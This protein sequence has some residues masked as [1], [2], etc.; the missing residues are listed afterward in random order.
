MA[1]WIFQSLVT[2][3][4]LAATV[5]I[6]CRFGRIGP[7][8]RHALWVVVLVKFVTPP[9]VVWPWAAPDPFGL[10]HGPEVT[11]AIVFEVAKMPHGV[12]GVTS[13]AE[14]AEIAATRA[15]ESPES[16]EP[17]SQ[18][19][20]QTSTVLV[21]LWIAGSVCLLAIEGVRLLRQA[22]RVAMALP[23]A[24]AIEQRV[25]LLA[26][27]LAVSPVPVLTMPGAMSPVVWCLGRP[28][29]LWPAELGDQGDACID[30]LIVHELAHIARRDHI[31]G[32]LELVAGVM[33][34]WNP[35][36]WSVRRA[37]REQAELACDAW[38]ISALPNGRRA[39]AESLLALSSLGAAPAASIAAI[40]GVRASSRRVLERRLVMIMKGRAPLRLP[41]A[42][43]IA[44]VVVTMASLPAWASGQIAGAPQ[45]P[46]PATSAQQQGVPVVV[47][48]SPQAKPPAQPAQPNPPAPP[49]VVPSRR[50]T[51]APAASTHVGVPV[52]PQ[53]KET[54]RPARHVAITPA[55]HT[56]ERMT[57]TRPPQPRASF[58]FFPAATELTD[59]GQK[60]VEKFVAQRESIQ[61][62]VD[63]KIEAER[64][65]TIKQ[66]QALQDQYA[67]AGKLDEAVA[68]RDYLRA[69]GPG[70][71]KVS[72]IRRAP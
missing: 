37:L 27:Q 61:K 47:A 7:V 59:E 8:A 18:S 24:P 13:N 52:E 22:R 20:W 68:I 63:A 71:S 64:Q 45:P 21:A 29:L 51:P 25:A 43:L 34:W 12:P 57:V 70:D 40:V 6:L 5:A 26:N 32:W 56:Q 42:G 30:G 19:A 14:V 15:S 48:V 46:P 3:A 55:P 53:F 69:G 35:L 11:E 72:W 39:Y 4:A 16:P 33:W 10:A 41:W 17:R 54:P 58:T 60:L 9:L 31:V 2:T 28:R 23:A 66:L 49:T 1:W 36:F 38:V 62:E 50:V 44:L 65:T 67:K